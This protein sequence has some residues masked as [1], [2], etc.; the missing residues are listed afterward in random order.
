MRYSLQ[1]IYTIKTHN[2]IT[3][4]QQTSTKRDKEAKCLKTRAIQA[5]EPGPLS[6]R[7]EN[8]NKMFFE[9]CNQ[10]TSLLS[11]G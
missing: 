8:P 9:L 7:S 6:D 5:T 10:L 4:K 1:Y 11:M 3:Q 2:I